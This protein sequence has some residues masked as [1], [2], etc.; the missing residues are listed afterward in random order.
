MPSLNI[1]TAAHS[2]GRIDLFF[3]GLLVLSFDDVNVFRKFADICRKQAENIQ[4][5]GK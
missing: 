5:M 1:E 3:N 4:R 2:D